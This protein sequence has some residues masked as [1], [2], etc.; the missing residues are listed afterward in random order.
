MPGHALLIGGLVGAFG[1]AVYASHR[2]YR[3]S[4][5]RWMLWQPHWIDRNSG[6]SD[7]TRR[8]GRRAFALLFVMTGAFLIL[9]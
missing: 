8:H 6:V 5:E 7:E 3:E 4:G 1:Y 9:R 2:A